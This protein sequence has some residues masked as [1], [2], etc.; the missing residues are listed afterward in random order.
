[1]AK[2]LADLVDINTH[3]PED[4]ALMEVTYDDS[5]LQVD[6]YRFVRSLLTNVFDPAIMTSWSTP[7]STPAI[8]RAIAGRL[9]AA[10]F[11]LTLYSE[12]SDDEPFLAQR[13]YNEATAMLTQV[14]DGTLTILDPVTSEE[15]V[16]LD[17]L[18]WG[19]EDFYPNDDVP[20]KFSMDM[21][22][23]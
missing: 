10:K 19:R 7:T 4:K 20:P 21:S 9:I 16:V 18:R 22:F 14:R 11:Y 13:L 6:T 17:D 12:D 15:I 3:L 5:G 1:V 2:L 8:I 23:G